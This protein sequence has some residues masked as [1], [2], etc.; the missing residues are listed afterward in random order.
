MSAAF[1]EQAP[2]TTNKVEALG[3]GIIFTNQRGGSVAELHSRKQLGRCIIRQ[4]AT[5]SIQNGD[6]AS[7]ARPAAGEPAAL[8]VC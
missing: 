8:D 1:S 2:Y 5:L 7:V 3:R 4:V 6:G